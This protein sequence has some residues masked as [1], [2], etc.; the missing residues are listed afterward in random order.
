MNL[1]VTQLSFSYKC[2]P[3]LKNVNF[4]LNTG[5]YVCVLG[6]NGAGK[7]TLF[8]CILGLLKGYHGQ[9]KLDGG[10][11]RRLSSKELAS[12]IAYIPQMHAAAFPFTVLDMVMMGTTA[13]FSAI[14]TPGENQRRSAEQALAML[15][16][17]QFATRS[18][19]HL[20][21]GEQQLV[22]IA[23]ALAQNARIL[24]MDEPCA[25]LDYGN[26]IRVMEQLARLAQ[27]GYLI[28]QSTHNPEHAF[29]FADQVMVLDA[30][31]TDALGPPE[32]ILTEELLQTIYQTPIH[33]HT[34]PETGL[35]ICVPDTRR[36]SDVDAL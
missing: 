32:V 28:I 10:D 4:S 19:E 11:V 26:Q 3:V 31:Q 9:I 21:G 12:R 36:Y 34:V 27:E 14:A 23:R 20:S 30:G 18:Y 15:G 24:L 29:L 5:N 16:M 17:E 13:S 2:F 25:N 22:L 6:K 1:Q 35:R 33:L 7:S 8:K